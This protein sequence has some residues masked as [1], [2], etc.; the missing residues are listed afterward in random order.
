[1]N[2]SV[3]FGD[4]MLVSAGSGSVATAS[5]DSAGAYRWAYAGGS[6]ST[7]DSSGAATPQAVAA[8]ASTVVVIGGFGELPCACTTSPPG[9]TLALSGATLTAVSAQDLFLASFTP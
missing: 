6:P 5:F 7:A 4:G 2:G 1:L 8:S 3:N 9:T